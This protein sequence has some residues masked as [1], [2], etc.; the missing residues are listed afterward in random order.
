MASHTFDWGKVSSPAYLRF[1]IPGVMLLIM[2]ALIWGRSWWPHLVMLVGLA[3]IIWPLQ[4]FRLTDRG[5]TDSQAGEP[6]AHR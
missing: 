3:L 2:A 5:G 4:S 6:P 1:A